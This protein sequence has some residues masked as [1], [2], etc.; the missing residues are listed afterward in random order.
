MPIIM[1]I[2]QKNKKLLCSFGIVILLSFTSDLPHNNP[3]VKVA[4]ALQN[5][6]MHGDLSA[7]IDMDTLWHQDLYALGPVAG[8]HGEITVMNG[9]PLS[10]SVIDTYLRSDTSFKH[11]ASMLVYAYVHKWKGIKIEQEVKNMNELEQVIIQTAEQNKIDPNEPFPFMIRTRTKNI[12]FHVIDWKDSTT[13]TFE[14]HKMFAHELY[15]TNT[16]VLMLGFYSTK[17][18]GIFTPHYSKIH[19]HVVAVTHK[20]LITGHLDSIETLDNFT[21]Y[22]PEK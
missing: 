6:M 7:Q 16:N 9:K 21:I 1:L 12:G 5:I 2:A 18:Q 14:N 11:K 13:H 4:G 3:E 10:T 19:A 17:H 8:L 20:P 22:L 15:E